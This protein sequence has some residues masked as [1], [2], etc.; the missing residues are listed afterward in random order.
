MGDKILD[1]VMWFLVFALFIGVMLHAAGFSQSVGT[2]FT[3]VNTLGTTLEAA[4]SKQT[5]S[6]TGGLT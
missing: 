4:G 6:G 3:G 1:I 2:L 5:A